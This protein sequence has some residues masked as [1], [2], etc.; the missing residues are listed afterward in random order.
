[1]QRMFIDRKKQAKKRIARFTA[2]AAIT[3][4][5]LFAL[6]LVI[7]LIYGEREIVEGDTGDIYLADLPETESPPPE[8]VAAP[9]IQRPDFSAIF[10]STPIRNLEN[11]EEPEA[12]AELSQEETA[13]RQEPPEPTP[14]PTPMPSPDNEPV[15][16]AE[17]PPP[18]E[19]PAAELPPAEPPQAEA[20][21][22]EAPE[23]ITAR[24]FCQEIL[25]A[26]Q[27]W[28]HETSAIQEL[29]DN[30]VL[31]NFIA[32]FNLAGAVTSSF[33]VTATNIKVQGMYNDGKFFIDL[34]F[35]GENQGI[36]F[37]AWYGSG[38]RYAAA[39]QAG[40]EVQ[41]VICNG[42]RPSIMSY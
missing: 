35:S 38:S 42:S 2:T 1:M 26:A 30:I 19:P 32:N 12:S 25:N 4:S 27:S 24:Q 14:E 33:E 34:A 37:V 40:G 10:D 28:W 23:S 3:F 21:P 31:S 29:S 7:I 18:E 16:P 13:A 6:V 5:L 8:E 9:P 39:W 36:R 22:P 11:P 20:P 17:L 41:A 15:R